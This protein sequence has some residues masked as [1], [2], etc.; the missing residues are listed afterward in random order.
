M[1]RGAE[2]RL[3]LESLRRSRNAQRPSE[4]RNR[5]GLQ[6]TGPA[7]WDSGKTRRTLIFRGVQ[8]REGEPPAGRRSGVSIGSG[9]PQTAFIGR[10]TAKDK[11][12]AIAAAIELYAVPRRHQKRMLALRRAA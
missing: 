1:T 3:S 10:V 7:G 11:V 8:L 2:A 5:T 9:P 4:P 12:A 6:R